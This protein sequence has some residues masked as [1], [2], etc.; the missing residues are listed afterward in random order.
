MLLL[1]RRKKIYKQQCNNWICREGC[2]LVRSSSLVH[3]S[4]TSGRYVLH[5]SELGLPCRKASD[6]R[7]WQWM[8]W[9][10]I[11]ARRVSPL[12]AVFVLCIGN[13]AETS[14]ARSVSVVDFDFAPAVFLLQRHSINL[15]EAARLVLVLDFTPHDHVMYARSARLPVPV[16]RLTTAREVYASDI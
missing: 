11:D 12:C 9:I 4:T 6:R 8:L 2:H 15:H 10:V 13:F 5:R 16:V 7:P 1:L 3:S 14:P